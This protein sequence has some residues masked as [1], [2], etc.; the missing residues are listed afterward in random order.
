[1]KAAEQ[2]RQHQTSAPKSSKLAKH[3]PA[4]ISPE[5]EQVQHHP[6][7]APRESAEMN[8]DEYFEVDADHHRLRLP[9]HIAAG[10]HNDLPNPENDH[11]R[12][13]SHYV[14]HPFF[15]AKHANKASYYLQ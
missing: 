13:M 6:A 15:A 7:S 4:S 8:D 11:F 14:E 9:L 2:A 5:S 3:E 1:M 10:I 12:P